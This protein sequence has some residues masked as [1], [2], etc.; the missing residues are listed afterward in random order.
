M[1]RSANDIL[2]C[3]IKTEMSKTCVVEVYGI[4]MKKPKYQI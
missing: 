1:N 4:K 3:M 2:D